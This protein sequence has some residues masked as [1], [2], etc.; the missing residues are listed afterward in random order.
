M[1]ATDYKPLYKIGKRESLQ[2]EISEHLENT[3]EC[4]I[5]IILKH[6]IMKH[7]LTTKEK[8]IIIQRRSR[9]DSTLVK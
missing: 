6:H 4:N 9:V 7:L 3:K 8:I 1:T 5:H 2:K